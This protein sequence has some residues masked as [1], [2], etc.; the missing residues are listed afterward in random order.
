VIF[1]VQ[2]GI[3]IVVILFAGLISIMAGENNILRYTFGLAAVATQLGLFASAWHFRSKSLPRFDL[4]IAAETLVALGVFSLISGIVLAIFATRGSVDDILQGRIS[5]SDLDLLLTSFGEGLLAS[6]VAP[7]LATIL[8]QIEM[9]KYA[10]HPSSASGDPLDVLRSD[11]DKVAKA[12]SQ[13]RIET[14][15]ATKHTASFTKAARSIL[16]SLNALSSDISNARGVVPT[17]LTSVSLEIG[18]AG[19]GVAAA[20]KTAADDVRSGGGRVSAALETAA[21]NIDVEGGRV[22][23]AL[24]TTGSSLGDF[25]NGVVSGA[26]TM[27]KMTNELDSLGKEAGAA[28]ALL[29]R[30]QQLIDRVTDFV[31]AERS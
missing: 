29:T 11:A 8:R 17:A 27:K 31:R 2:A 19:Q 16:D 12:L 4:T 14:E 18:S 23:K 15:A 5:S 26:E 25:T 21:G 3:A 20:F 7:V 6:A 30:L 1:I 28:T 22:S 9:L 10:P 24:A 13:L